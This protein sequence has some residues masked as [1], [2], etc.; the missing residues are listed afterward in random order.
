MK[1]TIARA[2]YG[3]LIFIGQVE[4]ETHHVL[5]PAFD[6]VLTRAGGGTVNDAIACRVPL[7]LVEEPG[8]WQVEQI[9]QSCVALQIAESVT[10][11]EFKLRGR[12]CVETDDGQL[13][14]LK[15]QQERMQRIPNHGEVW[16]CQELLA[17]I[18]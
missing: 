2:H 6:V 15:E 5:F 14:R 8:M 11:E 7:V 18:E 9:R 17:L 16:L 1:R 13:K 10:L 3:K 12:D 4:A